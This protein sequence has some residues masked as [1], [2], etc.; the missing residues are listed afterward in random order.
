[1]SIEQSEAL[2]HTNVRL[3]IIAQAKLCIFKSLFLLAHRTQHQALERARLW[4]DEIRQSHRYT[5][6]WT[7]T[8]TET[9]TE[10]AIES[11]GTHLHGRVEELEHC[12][13]L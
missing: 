1:M 2:R 13:L 6:R 3:K 8:E 10:H 7:E 5:K 9:E 11:T 4:S 12:R